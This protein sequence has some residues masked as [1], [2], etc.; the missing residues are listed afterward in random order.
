MPFL[1][2]IRKGFGRFHHKQ[3]LLLGN[4]FTI[5]ECIYFFHF[6]TFFVYVYYCLPVIN[7]LLSA[8]TL[9]K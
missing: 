4:S 6:L 8:N 2:D 1:S 3:C 5:R 9:K 7:S